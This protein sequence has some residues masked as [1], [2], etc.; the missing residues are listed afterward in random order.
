M[1]LLSAPD[2]VA[3][4]SRADL[5][6]LTAILARVDHTTRR[7][8]IRS[9]TPISTVSALAAGSAPGGPATR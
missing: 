6:A 1:S 5:P 7:G 4:G 8:M 2:D 3:A 9:P